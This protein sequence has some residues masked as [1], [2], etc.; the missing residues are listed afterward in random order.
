[1]REEEIVV[2][3][4]QDERKTYMIISSNPLKGMRDNAEHAK[5]RTS[6]RLTHDQWQENTSGEWKKVSGH[7]I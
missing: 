1:M 3:T 6:S 4:L 5:G 7:G 2:E